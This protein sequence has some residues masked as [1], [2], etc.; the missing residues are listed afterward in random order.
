MLFG[1]SAEAT[2]RKTWI[3]KITKELKKHKEDKGMKGLGK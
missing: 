1:R 2:V 3:R